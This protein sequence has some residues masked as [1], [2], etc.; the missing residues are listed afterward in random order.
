MIILK[1]GPKIRFPF[2]LLATAVSVWQF[3][4]SQLASSTDGWTTCT[5]TWQTA[6][7]DLG[8]SGMKDATKTLMS[9]ASVDCSRSG[10]NEPIILDAANLST[11]GDAGLTQPPLAPDGSQE[12]PPPT[13][14]VLG[15][16]DMSV[17]SKAPTSVGHQW[18]ALHDAVA[19]WM[20]TAD[21]CVIVSLC[22]VGMESNMRHR[23]HI[24]RAA[25]SP[26]GRCFMSHSLIVVSSRETEQ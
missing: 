9:L 15:A 6:R 17:V 1:I 20:S 16:S 18:L 11:A 8:G 3:F 5:K 12:L 19:K 23:L 10:K 7:L 21:A 2:P 26:P 24:L 4:T 13:D 22:A 14:T 25:G